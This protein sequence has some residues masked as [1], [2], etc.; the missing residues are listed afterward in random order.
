MLLTEKMSTGPNHKI[1][2]F[3][4]TMIYFPLFLLY[5][6]WNH[7]G[8]FPISFTL[9]FSCTVYGITHLGDKYNFRY[10]NCIVHAYNLDIWQFT[11]T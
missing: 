2:F 5:I 4:S 11:K 9:H 8:G 6:S 1:F 7:P 10:E 3:I